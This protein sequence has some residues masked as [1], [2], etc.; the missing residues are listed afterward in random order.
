MTD[1][2]Q[3]KTLQSFSPLS[4]FVCSSVSYSGSKVKKERKKNVRGNVSGCTSHR[5]NRALVLFSSRWVWCVLLDKN[6][7]YFSFFGMLLVRNLR[8]MCLI[9][10][11]FSDVFHFHWLVLCIF[12]RN[13][14]WICVKKH[15]AGWP[16][17][18]LHQ[19][20]CT[21]E[22][23]SRR[24]D[25]VFWVNQL[26]PLDWRGAN[27]SGWFYQILTCV[28]KALLIITSPVLECLN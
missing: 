13:L 6:P 14:Q 26:C 5:R 27:L 11:D 22:E 15:A 8:N 3:H 4:A 28:F 2:I 16:K 1:G 21:R 10:G 23:F 25:R 18:S 9:Q 12:L 19:Q 7:D 17:C 24:G 20:Y